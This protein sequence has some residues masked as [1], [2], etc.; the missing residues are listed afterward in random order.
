MYTLKPV[1]LTAQ[2]Y[3]LEQ[4]QTVSR[5]VSSL[6]KQCGFELRLKGHSAKPHENLEIED[7]AKQ[8][9]FQD[10]PLH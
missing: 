1:T 6:F 5:Q 2:D 8:S 10:L 9:A 4:S 3:L 7:G